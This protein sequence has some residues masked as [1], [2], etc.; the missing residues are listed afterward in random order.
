MKCFIDFDDT[1]MHRSKMTDD[2]YA[3]FGSMSAEQLRGHY[4]DYRR[5]HP[6]TITGFTE[7]LKTLGIDGDQLRELFFSFATRA[8][9]YVF[10]D[11]IAFVNTLKAAQHECI[12]LSFDAEPALWQKPKIE[13]S[14]LAPLFDRVEVISYPKV[15]FMRSLNIATPFVFIDDKREE[16]DAM[17]AAFPD[18]LCLK[19]DRGE[20]LLPHLANIDAFSHNNS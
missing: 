12:L 18:A 6:F 11:A 4:A 13:A 10:P 9:E 20:P 1:L 8:K 19:H 17:H 15:A 3:A 2:I 7:Y 5:D 16:V 14:G